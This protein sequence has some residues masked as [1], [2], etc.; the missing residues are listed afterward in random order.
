M[1][2]VRWTTPGRTSPRPVPSPQQTYARSGRVVYH[3][4]SRQGWLATANADHIVDYAAIMLMLID[5]SV[6]MW[7]LAVIL[8]MLA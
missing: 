1:S 3:G 7:D 6:V 2:L 8:K 4:S 5:A